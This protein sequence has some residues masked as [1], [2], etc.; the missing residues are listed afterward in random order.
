MPD[1]AKSSDV[2]IK[3]FSVDTIAA[4]TE[5]HIRRYYDYHFAPES[6]QADDDGRRYAATAK[7]FFNTA[8]S[9]D[10]NEVSADSLQ[11]LLS[12]EMIGNGTVFR[13]YVAAI[14]KRISS[15]G[16]SQ[17]RT[18]SYLQVEDNDIDQIRAVADEVAPFVDFFVI[19]TGNALLRAGLT[20]IDLPGLWF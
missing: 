15:F 7:D 6:D 17:S 18:L 10:D 14:E 5:S 8:F 19:K 20:F 2:E 16:V 9:T 13:T 12:A 4:M 3:F 11:S 1:D